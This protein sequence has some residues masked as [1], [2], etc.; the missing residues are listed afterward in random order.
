MILNSNRLLRMILIISRLLIMI[1]NSNS[2]MSECSDILM[3]RG[4]EVGNTTR[5]S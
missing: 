5:I 4:D 2:D 3:C 1:L